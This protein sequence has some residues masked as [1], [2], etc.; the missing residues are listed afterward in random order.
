MLTVT[1]GRR[2]VLLGGKP[3][4][5]SIVPCIAVA[6]II[7]SWGVTKVRTPGKPESRV[8]S[9]F[10]FAVKSAKQEGPALVFELPPLHEA[11]IKSGARKQRDAPLVSVPSIHE[12]KQVPSSCIPRC[13]T[14]DCASISVR[15]LHTL[16][17]AGTSFV[18]AVSIDSGT[19]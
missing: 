7:N 17:R 11:W 12:S 14:A 19:D 9:K 18:F 6:S 16:S 10:C 2:D 4:S 8:V 13:S 5:S 1:S 15:Y 3:S